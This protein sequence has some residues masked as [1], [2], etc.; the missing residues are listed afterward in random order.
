MDAWMPVP[1]KVRLSRWKAFVPKAC[2]PLASVV[3][4][5]PEVSLNSDQV[6]ALVTRKW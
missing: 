3:S 6:F 5:P 2:E 4:V 1:L